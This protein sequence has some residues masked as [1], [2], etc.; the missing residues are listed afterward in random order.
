MT[1]V[2]AAMLLGAAL[3][4]PVRPGRRRWRELTT[5][6][7]PAAQPAPRLRP[8]WLVVGIGAVGGVGWALGGATAALVV[9]GLAG[10]AAV[11]LQRGLIG[12]AG[13]RTEDDP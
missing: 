9:T 7:T 3:L 4:P 8:A 11:G 6:A 5:A 13:E 1:T 12:R 2:A 10:V